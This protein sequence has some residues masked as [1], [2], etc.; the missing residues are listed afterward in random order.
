MKP[1]KEHQNI[2]VEEYDARAIYQLKTLPTHGDL[3]LNGKIMKIGD[4]W[5][6]GDVRSG[7][8]Q[9]KHTKNEGNVAAAKDSFQYTIPLS[10]TQN[11]LPSTPRSACLPDANI[12][13]GGIYTFPIDIVVV[14]F[15]KEIR[16][17]EMSM[18]EDE[19]KCVSRN[20]L[21]YSSNTSQIAKYFGKPDAPV[22]PSE[23]QI[24]NSWKRF[25]GSTVYENGGRDAPESS[26]AQRWEFDKETD[27]IKIMNNSSSYTGMANLRQHDR[28]KL[29]AT[30]S[31]T[32]ADDDLIGVTV[33][34]AEVGGVPHTLTFFRA[35][36][37][38]GKDSSTI[39]TWFLAYCI[40]N[41]RTILVD[42]SSSATNSFGNTKSQGWRSLG[43]TR[44][45]VRREE[46]VVS[47]TCSQ[48]SYTDPDGLDNDVLPQDE[49]TKI[50]YTIPAGSPFA[51]PAQYGFGALSQQFAK[52]EDMVFL[53]LPP[54]VVP[55]EP[56]PEPDPLWERFPV[57]YT[58]TYLSKQT[59]ATITLN[60]APMKP[61]DTF[62]HRDLDEGKVCAVGTFTGPG[63]EYFG[64]RACVNDYK[65]TVGR[66]N[67]KVIEWPYPE[68]EN[69][70]T[71][72]KECGEKTLTEDDL[73]FSVLFGSSLSQISI[74]LDPDRTDLL[75]GGKQRVSI[76]PTSFTQADVYAG[77]VKIKHNCANGETLWRERMSF[78]VCTQ[79]G[80]C[81]QKTFY[82]NV[83]PLPIE[84]PERPDVIVTP[85]GCVYKMNFYGAWVQVGTCGL[86][87]ELL[88]R[89]IPDPTTPGEVLYLPEGDDGEPQTLVTIPDP[90]DPTKLIWV[91]IPQVVDSIDKD[92]K[93]EP[94]TVV[95]NTT[96]EKAIITLDLWGDRDEVAPPAFDVYAGSS[97]IASG[98]VTN[99]YRVNQSGKGSQVFKFTCESSLLENNEPVRVVFTND[100]WVKY[101]R[102][103]L[104]NS[105]LVNGK[106]P[107]SYDQTTRQ[108]GISKNV[109]MP[110]LIK[111]RDGAVVANGTWPMA[112][113]T[114]REEPGNCYVLPDGTKW[115]ADPVGELKPVCD[116]AVKNSCSFATVDKTP[117]ILGSDDYIM[118]TDNPEDKP[119]DKPLY[120]KP[121]DTV[122]T[123][124]DGELQPTPMPYTRSFT[125]DAFEW[126]GP[127][128]YTVPLGT[129]F[130]LY[131]F[132]SRFYVRF[133]VMNENGN[134]AVDM[135]S[136][137]VKVSPSLYTSHFINSEPQITLGRFPR[138]TKAQTVF[139][140][141]T[142]M[143]YQPYDTSTQM[144]PYTKGQYWVKL[145]ST[146]SWAGFVA[147]QRPVDVA[148]LF[149]GP[150][151]KGGPVSKV[152]TEW[153]TNENAIPVWSYSGFGGTG[154]SGFGLYQYKAST[155]ANDSKI[156]G[157]K[158]S[159]FGE[160]WARQHFDSSRLYGNLNYS[161]PAQFK[162]WMN[163]QLS[164]I[165]REGIRPA[166]EKLNGGAFN[167]TPPKTPTTMTFKVRGVDL[168]TGQTKYRTYKIHWATSG[169][170]SKQ[171]DI[172][173]NYEP[174][175]LP[176]KPGV[177]ICQFKGDGTPGNCRILD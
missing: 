173:T 129:A 175:F 77:L 67:I 9:Y 138:T 151:T 1:V 45:E 89:I 131:F 2:I 100:D 148:K 15:P 93:C 132:S 28:L 24:F 141:K 32:S 36:S 121:I 169:F 162:G 137:A 37:F 96:R 62:T 41:T 156:Y 27:S 165:S 64:F 142:L 79:K 63:Q 104:V 123:P 8:F 80:K 18:M 47:A 58:V 90:K 101:D 124:I 136:S 14:P 111:G 50:T 42:K 172:L 4:K 61:G 133:D 43:R 153:V 66:F 102:N 25:S 127:N 134:S 68:T 166:S 115:I 94:V 174:S 31:S 103:L 114:S 143:D 108:G 86:W 69:N 52:F 95:P 53:E 161:P 21:F 46:N 147:S 91:K 145:G 85:E 60:G 5:T 70:E 160:F 13:Q 17:K 119:K 176:P 126:I 140:V 72:I 87:T 56:E 23:N 11:L 167:G 150:R 163:A 159:A 75:N 146:G 92:E 7:R 65:C 122:F 51:G 154:S 158:G 105:I 29:G 112:P 73:L 84:K 83:E 20:M 110:A 35:G 40:G 6:Q 76:T 71:T 98:S 99:L 57:T 139:P 10:D 118:E 109:G 54:P 78:N 149:Y 106:A 19:T 55:P 48:F 81:K 88:G 30:L 144:N 82:I 33:A 44:V 128:E 97:L 107:T 117:I 157:Y 3:M 113:F 16:N 34:Y 130:D 74:V 170:G 26:D 49:A 12:P 168:V 125:L 59:K 135:V 38:N 39:K 120:V 164:F 22:S 171:T 116:P 155:L 152:G 177:A